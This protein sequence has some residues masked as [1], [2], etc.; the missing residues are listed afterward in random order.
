MGKGGDGSLRKRERERKRETILDVCECHLLNAPAKLLSLV[1]VM[2]G[3]ERDTSWISNFIWGEKKRAGSACKSLLLSGRRL[4][5]IRERVQ[6]YKHIQHPLVLWQLLSSK[7]FFSCSLWNLQHLSGFCQ[8]LLF[9]FVLFFYMTILARTVQSQVIRC[10]VTS[11]MSFPLPPSFLILVPLLF[12][13]SILVLQIQLIW[14]S[15]N[16]GFA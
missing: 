5:L 11:L 15:S 6:T 2:C 4:P 8:D 7:Q 14:I 1:L 16:W 13:C 10:C 12:R 3:V 9:L